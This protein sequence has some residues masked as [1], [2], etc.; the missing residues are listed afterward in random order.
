MTRPVVCIAGGGTAGL[1]ALLRARQLMGERVELVLIS[2]EREFRYRSMCQERPLAPAPERSLTVA[3]LVSEAGATLVDDRL[4][5]VREAD[6]LVL[7]RNGDLLAFDYLLLATGARTEPV[8]R[9]G[10]VWER[11][12][13]PAAL[14]ETLAGLASGEVARVAVVIPLGARW[15]LP[16]YELA[17]VMGWT[18]GESGRVMLITTERSALGALGHAATEFVTNELRAAGVELRA[19]IEALDDSLGARGGGRISLRLVEEDERVAARA[20]TA[21][22]ARRRV[23]DELGSGLFGSVLDSATPRRPRERDD[24]IATFDRLISLPTV[25]GSVIGGVATDAAGFVLVD[26][27]LRVAGSRR[28]WAA[29]SCLA[30]GLE[31]SALAAQQ[32]DAAVAEIATAIGLR[33]PAPVD[34]FELTGVLLGGQ[35]EAWL[36]GNPPGTHQPST[37]CLW[38]PTGRAVGPCLAERIAALDP[39][40][41]GGVHAAPVGLPVRVHVA[42]AAGRTVDRGA[43]DRLAVRKARQR[44]IEERQL[45]AVERQE[46][47]ADAQLRTLRGR[48]RDLDAEVKSVRDQLRRAGYLQGDGVRRR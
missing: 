32:A 3:E 17:L 44:E 47:A 33:A 27:R 23:D 6:R 11:G 20:L 21:R 38:W 7:T 35:R 30:V 25:T 18:A 40:V 48:L 13:D 36:A 16:A 31:H 1:E 29:G 10:Q 46:R 45:M 22:P 4:I 28:V 41:L 43:G 15:P 14:D 8:L 12:R 39:A 42:P 9:Q 24:G 34:G 19:G 37:R 26:G 5:E 2:P